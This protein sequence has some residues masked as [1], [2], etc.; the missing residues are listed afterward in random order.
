[1]TVTML[2]HNTL[3]SAERAASR[4]TAPAGARQPDGIPAPAETDA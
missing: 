3:A 4:P 2:L 1:M